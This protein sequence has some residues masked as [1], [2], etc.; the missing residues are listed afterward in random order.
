MADTKGHRVGA[1]KTPGWSVRE[2]GG[3][4]HRRLFKQFE[5]TYLL[6]HPLEKTFISKVPENLGNLCTVIVD[7]AHSVSDD[8]V[9]DPVIGLAHQAK[10][11]REVH[12]GP[13]QPRPDFGQAPHTLFVKVFESRNR[14][15]RD[16][17][18]KPVPQQLDEQVHELL[19]P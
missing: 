6:S 13:D 17:V 14:E 3:L 19:P 15:L 18:P 11:E 1:T 16:A 5:G 9:H 2:G 10:I 8:I 12:L 4:G 7:D